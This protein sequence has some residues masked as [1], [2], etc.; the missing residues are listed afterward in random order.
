MTRKKRGDKVLMWVAPSFK[1]V[2]KKK[3]AERE[4]SIID[5]T[6]ELSRTF[7]DPAEKFTKK[8]NK[9]WGRLL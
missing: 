7:P 4:L 6:E 3:A 5:L 2:I 1:K 8:I 9:N